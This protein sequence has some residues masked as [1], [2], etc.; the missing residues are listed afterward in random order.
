MA[1]LASRRTLA[2]ALAVALTLI[3]ARPAAAWGLGSG[4]EAGL[5]QQGLDWLTSFWGQLWNPEPRNEAPA[6]AFEASDRGAGFDP[7]GNSLIAEPP[8]GDDGQ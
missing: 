3:A 5:W 1:R 4:R 2:L 8:P 6:S 7:N